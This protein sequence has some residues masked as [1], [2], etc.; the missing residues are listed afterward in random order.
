M[1]DEEYK[2]A[3]CSIAKNSTAGHIECAAR[4]CSG[5]RHGR[6]AFNDGPPCICNPGWTG[7][8]CSA[9][10]CPASC[11]GNGFCTDAGCVCYPGWQDAACATPSCPANCDGH[12]ACERGQCHCVAGWSGRDRSVP[13]RPSRAAVAERAMVGLFPRGAPPVHTY[14]R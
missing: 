8:D 6:C 10:L 7:S 4:L 14:R 11:S 3:D 1:C 12:G 9:E 2:G 5:D 13:T